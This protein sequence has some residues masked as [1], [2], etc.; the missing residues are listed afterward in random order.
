ML[1]AMRAFNRRNQPVLCSP[2]V[3]GGANTPAS[4]C[5]R[6]PSSTPRRCRRLPYQV[7]A[8]AARPSM[9][10]TCR[11]CRCSPARPWRHTEIGLMNFMIGQVARH[12]GIPG[13][14]QRLSGL[15]AG[16]AIRLWMLTLMAVLM[17]GNTSGI[18]QAGTRPAHCSMAKFIV[19]P[20][21]APWATAWPKG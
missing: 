17:S 20:N 7:I 16:R 14:H 6:W 19:D 3:L 2:F 1:S 8:T 18:R 12:Y 11:P 21:N 15:D 4:T 13:G 10:I 5:R 9:A